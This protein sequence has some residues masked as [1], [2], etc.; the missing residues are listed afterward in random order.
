M[1]MYSS[2]SISI[3]DYVLISRLQQIGSV[4]FLSKPT[5]Y[6]KF[7]LLRACALKFA[8]KLMVKQTGLFTFSPIDLYYSLHR[9]RPT[10]FVYY[11]TVGLH[12]FFI[13]LAKCQWRLGTGQ[14]DS[15]PN[16]VFA[17]IKEKFP[18]LNN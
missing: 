18:L 8:L 9:C 13:F 16:N 2:T 14:L 17:T 5:G 10:T 11:N 3:I 6:N 12:T 4:V 7:I 15:F 1:P